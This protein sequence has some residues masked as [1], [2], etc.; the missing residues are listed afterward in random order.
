MADS[1]SLPMVSTARP[2]A[3][4]SEKLVI[5]ILLTRIR[6]RFPPDEQTAAVLATVSASVG[7]GITFVVFGRLWDGV[8]EMIRV[9]NTT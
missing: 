5:N 3:A 7:L 8:V 2:T 6:T 1:V 4:S 9:G